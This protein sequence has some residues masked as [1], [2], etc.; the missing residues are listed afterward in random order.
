MNE[1]LDSSAV[2]IDPSN[3]KI[4]SGGENESKE[5]TA[6]A[7]CEPENEKKTEAVNNEL[8][9][10]TQFEGD[11]NLSL[12]EL[13]EVKIKTDNLETDNTEPSHSESLADETTSSEKVYS[14]HF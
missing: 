2:D 5:N 13:E 11:S 7:P 12:P 9:S 4:E 1:A 8:D 6:V 3:T 14:D 10:T